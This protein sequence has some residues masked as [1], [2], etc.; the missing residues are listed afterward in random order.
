MQARYE[1]GPAHVCVFQIANDLHVLRSYASPSS[2]LISDSRSGAAPSRARPRSQT[3]LN[4]S[5]TVGDPEYATDET[6]FKG[7]A[8]REDPG[9]SRR[10]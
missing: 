8:K 9:E 5:R 2:F 6:G 10:E 7:I 3:L 1:H 4:Q